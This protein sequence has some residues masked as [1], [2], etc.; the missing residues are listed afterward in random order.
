[1]QET[2]GTLEQQRTDG[3]RQMALDNRARLELDGGGRSR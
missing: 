1:L 3:H 2:A